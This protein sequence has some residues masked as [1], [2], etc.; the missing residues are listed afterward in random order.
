MTGDGRVVEIHSKRSGY[1]KHIVVDHGYGYKTLYAHL[2]KIDVKRGQE[3]KRGQKIGT[4]GSTGTSTAP[5]LHYEVIHKGKKV[6]PIHYCMD[7]LT[8]KEYQ[9]LANLASISNQSFD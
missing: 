3:V 6:N 7:G 9:E 8:P 1:G 5:H 4:V 2:D